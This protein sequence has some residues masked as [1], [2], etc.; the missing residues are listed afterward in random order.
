MADLL[1]E[2]PPCQHWHPDSSN[3]LRDYEV[4]EG[5]SQYRVYRNGQ[6]LSFA[7]PKGHKAH[8]LK[9]TINIIHTNDRS[10]SYRQ[11]D[12]YK[13]DGTSNTRQGCQIVW[14]AFNGPIPYGYKVAHHGETINDNL[15]NLYL[16][17]LKGFQ[18]PRK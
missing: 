12:L 2:S 17:P 5:Y 13:D 1:F 8:W 6:I 14:E 3:T 11:Y 9:G 4:P 18:K 15:D 16:V 7:G 10:Y